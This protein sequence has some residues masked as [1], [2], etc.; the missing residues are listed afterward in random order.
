MSMKLSKPQI[1]VLAAS[2]AHPFGSGVKLLCDGYTITLRV[3]AAEKMSYRVMTYVNGEFKGLWRSAK[4][5]CL[6][7]KFLRKLVK[8]LCSPSSKRKAEKVLG[9]RYV[10]KNPYYSETQT[11]YWPDW[12]SGKAALNHLNR[13]CESISLVE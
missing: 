10:K 9:K 2:L 6:E 12:S 11:S 3:E 1:E 13:V 7:S 5:E 8:P 4:N